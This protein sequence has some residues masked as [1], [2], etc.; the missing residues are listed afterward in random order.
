MMQSILNLIGRTKELFL[1]DIDNL[2]KELS[3][4]ISNYKFFV[5]I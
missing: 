1:D 2:E 3:K 5:I 4:I